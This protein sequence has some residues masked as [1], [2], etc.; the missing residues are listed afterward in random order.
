MTGFDLEKFTNELVEYTGTNKYYAYPLAEQYTYT[1]GVRHVS[2]RTDSYWLI[3][4]I[5]TLQL[6]DEVKKESFQVWTI[7]TSEDGSARLYLEDGNGN[8][9]KE[10]KIEYTD[11]PLS[12]FTYWFINNTL[13]LPSEY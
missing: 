5:F 7:I 3:N 2:R 12:K 13:I 1:D 8:A 6:L 11:F 9:V 4:A 10:I